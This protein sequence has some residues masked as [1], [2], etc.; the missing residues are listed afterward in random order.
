MAYGSA[1]GS[2]EI[3]LMP[4]IPFLTVTNGIRT[5]TVHRLL[6][7]NVPGVTELRM[8]EVKRRRVRLGPLLVV[9]GAPVD[10]I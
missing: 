6:R 10:E 4:S 2:V 8:C 9:H 7:Q 1:C 5:S 3:F